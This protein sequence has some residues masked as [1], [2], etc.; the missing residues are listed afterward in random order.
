MKKGAGKA[1]GS[2]F[3]RDI[4]RELSLWWTNYERDD[5]F[6][7]TAA[8]GGRATNRAKQ[9]KTTAG[10]YGDITYTDSL[11]ADLLKLF[12]FE[13]KRGYGHWC[14]LDVFDRPV[15]AKK[16]CKPT[17]IEQFWMQASQS[18]L[19]AGSL[20]PVVIFRR[21]SRRPCILAPKI[22]LRDVF[23]YLGPCIDNKIFTQ[24]CGTEVFVM[25]MCNFLSFCDPEAL[26]EMIK[27]KIGHE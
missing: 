22:F 9:G 6:W 14:L 11:G 8:S 5:I 7:R 21:D 16:L 17:I 24:L 15:P 2:Q 20:Y 18:C 19:D 13:L 3:E 26:Q 4:C 1:K 27:E 23:P 25:G 10:A 12:C